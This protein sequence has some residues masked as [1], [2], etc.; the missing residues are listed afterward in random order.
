[1][2]FPKIV[3]TIYH[4]KIVSLLNNSVSQNFKKIKKLPSC[5]VFTRS[6]NLQENKNCLGGLV[7]MV[8]TR[9]ISSLAVCLPLLQWMFLRALGNFTV[10]CSSKVSECTSRLVG[11]N[12]VNFKHFVFAIMPYHII[13]GV[14]YC[15]HV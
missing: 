10:C 12:L 13:V 3:S 2:F 11:K 7:G 14:K 15:L 6:N 8:F 5:L 4:T 1:M 9:S